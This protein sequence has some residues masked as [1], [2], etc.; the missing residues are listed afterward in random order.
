MLF[1]LHMLLRPNP[2]KRD[3]QDAQEFLDLLLPAKKEEQEETRT[4]VKVDDISQ[5]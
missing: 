4:E 1:D 5:I 2:S 3:D